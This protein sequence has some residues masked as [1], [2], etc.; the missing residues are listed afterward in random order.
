MM[1][2]LTSLTMALC[3]SVN[4][5]TRLRRRRVQVDKAYEG[6]V[7]E[8]EEKRGKEGERV[9]GLYCAYECQPIFIRA[10]CMTQWSCMCI[11]R[12]IEEPV[13]G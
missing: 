2:I 5:F 13:F 3:C 7:G 9:R 4:S 12:R 11:Y 8:I 1:H 6:I 10:K